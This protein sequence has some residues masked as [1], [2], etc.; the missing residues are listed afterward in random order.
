MEE[1]LKSFVNERSHIK[2]QTQSGMTMSPV[3]MSGAKHC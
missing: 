3:R 2:G 1:S